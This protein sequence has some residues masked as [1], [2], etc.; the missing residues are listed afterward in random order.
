M[1][2]RRVRWFSILCLSASSCE[3]RGGSKSWR[4]IV[5]LAKRFASGPDC[6]CAMAAWRAVV[7]AFPSLPFGVMN[8]RAMRR[9]G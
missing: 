1:E 5:T 9:C 6:V 3:V 4:M 8:P 2:A 7:G